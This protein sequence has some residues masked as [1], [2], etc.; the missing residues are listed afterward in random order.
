MDSLRQLLARQI[1]LGPHIASC[2]PD[3]LGT[4]ENIGAGQR[5]PLARVGEELDALG[6]GRAALLED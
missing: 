5:L 1:L 2:L 6:V 3:R 4:D